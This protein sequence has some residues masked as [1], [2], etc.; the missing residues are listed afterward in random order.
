MLIGDLI[1]AVA[2]GYVVGSFPTGVIVTRL[3]GK[4]D[5]RF[6]GS[7]HT[8]GRNTYRQVG[9]GG[10]A[11]VAL[12]DVGKGVLAAWLA[13]RLTGNSWTLVAAGLAAIIGHCWSVYIGFA[14]GM[15]LSTMGGLFFWQLPW[16]PFLAAAMWGLLYLA[17]RNSPRAVMLMTVLM[18]PLFWL[19]WRLG[20]ASP[21]VL[22]LGLSGLAVIFVRN[23]TQLRVYEQRMPSK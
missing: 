4:P 10:A 21:E 6:S 8:G 1:I 18:A 3:L 12:V 16:A 14:G 17:V 15:G 7:G 5:V 20:Y 2:L 23:L 22:A 9:L 19:A 13:L 11:L